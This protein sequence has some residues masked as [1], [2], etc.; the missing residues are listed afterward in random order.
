MAARMWL[1]HLVRSFRDRDT[2]RRTQRRPCRWWLEQLETRTVPAGHTLWGTEGDDTWVFSPG[3]GPYQL[4][5]SFNG[6]TSVLHAV[7]DVSIS[8][9]GGTDRVNIVG[10]AGNDVFSVNTG[11]FW[12]TLGAIRYTGSD[13]T[14]SDIESWMYNGSSGDD[15]LYGPNTNNIWVS[16]SADFGGTNFGAY[17]SIENLVGGSANDTFEFNSSAYGNGG[18]ELGQCTG[19]LS[20]GLGFNVVHLDVFT[21]WIDLQSARVTFAN[22]PI[23]YIGRFDGIQSFTAYGGIL[24][25]KNENAFWRIT[26][27]DSGWVHGNNSPSMFFTGI[28]QLVGGIGVD[29]FF[30]E[31]LGSVSV[32]INGG[33]WNDVLE[34]TGHSTSVSVDLALGSATAVRGGA[35]NSIFGIKDVYGG[36]GLNTLRGDAEANIFYLPLSGGGL[37]NGRDGADIYNFG[38][39]SVYAN[40]ALTIADSGADAAIDV[41]RIDGAWDTPNVI[42]VEKNGAATVVTRTNSTSSPVTFSGIENAFVS[43]G[44]LDDTLIDPG[45]S[46][47]TLL[48]GPGDDT[49]IVQDTTGPVTADGEDGSDTY[50]LNAGN[51][52]GPVSMNDTGSSGTDTVTVN[53]TVGD[54]AITQDNTGI[55]LNGETIAL[56]GGN[57]NLTINGAGGIDSFAVQG[58]PPVVANVVGNADPRLA[59]TTSTLVSATALLYGVDGLTISTVV[60]GTGSPSGFVTFYDGTTELGAVNL[61]NNAAE[62]VLGNSTL[63]IGSHTITAVYS[64]DSAFARS[65]AA[66]MVT[67]VV[68]TTV[69]GLVWLD[70]NDDGEVN[71][72]ETAIEGVN[73]TLTGID[74]LG[75]SVNRV[76]QSDTDGIYSFTDLRPSN[77]AGYT[78]TQTQP[79]EYIDGRDSLGTINN[80]LVGSDSVNDAFSGIV[81]PAGSFAENYNFGERPP[82]GGSVGAGQTA[83]IGFWQNRNGQNLIMALNGGATATQL[84]SWLAATFPNMYGMLDGMTNSQ[85]AAHYKTLFSRNG[86]SS[87][88][89]PPKMD[90][91]VMA[92]ALAVFVTN[93]T[94]AGTTAA[95]YGFQVSQY[96][97]GSRTFNVGNRGAAFGVANNTSLSVMDLLLAVNARS[98]NGLLYDTNGD[99]V[100]S[101]E[102]ASLRTMAN[103]VFSLINEAGGV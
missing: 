31:P 29:K 80:V 23:T 49:I 42:T 73:I 30:I 54:D 17:W 36:K 66:T 60:S 4:N 68:P 72:G 81:L 45:G 67:I 99:G 52:L 53:G 35:P 90:A 76:T 11:Y 98:F 83:T 62:L 40:A 85:V 33:S 47:L 24:F 16:N 20:G 61:T 89:G 48:G 21:P 75:Q 28:G 93:Q 22:H 69:H 101:P 91:Q 103:D 57:L 87:P 39:S 27:A 96:G 25:G 97:V 71:F 18:D 94:L 7:T 79:A 32:G 14:A 34:Y 63:A 3:S 8:G 92:T 56:G 51:L 6:T 64:G 74:D 46:N 50:I 59:T 15:T 82:N 19:R 65:N 44:P 58:N 88:G 77:S 37:L 55:V 5:V 12:V 1:R 95:A 10:T 13:S 102:E 43:G 26:G 70:F 9:L 41:V 100:I 78:I 84:G 2:S 38:F 86:Q